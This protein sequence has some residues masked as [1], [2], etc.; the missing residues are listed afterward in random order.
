MRRPARCACSGLPGFLMVNALFLL[1][2]LTAQEPDLLGSAGWYVCCIAGCQPATR[3]IANRRYELATVHGK[4]RDLGIPGFSHPPTGASLLG[5][6]LKFAKCLVALCAQIED[7]CAPIEVM[8]TESKKSK[9]AETQ[10]LELLQKVLPKATH[11]AQLAGKIYQAVEQELKAKARLVAFDKFCQ[12][13]E[14]PDLDPKTVMEVKGQLAA[15][16]DD[17][18]ITLKPNKKDQSL[19]VE[20]SL[21]NGAQLSSAIAVKAA[22]DESIEDPASELKFAPFPVSLPGDPELIWLLAKR[23]N[24][25]PEEA[26]IAL[27]KVEENFLGLENGPKAD[28]RPRRAQLPR[29]H[30]PRALRPAPGGRTQ[31]TL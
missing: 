31:A 7:N 29:I 24:L 25:T 4:G 9:T 2:V 26:G 10:L 16:F 17:G 1:D 20:I 12:K 30:Q 15:S 18:D 13:V 3:P 14:L 5:T 21:P 19:A 6:H 8:K 11:D 28:P 27:S 23:E 22:T